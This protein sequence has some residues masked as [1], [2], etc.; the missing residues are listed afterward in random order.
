MGVSSL[1]ARPQVSPSV[2]S[3]RA[4]P[5]NAYT[6]AGNASETQAQASL[7]TQERTSSASVVIDPRLM[8]EPTDD[9]TIMHEPSTL[10]ESLRSLAH[11]GPSASASSTAFTH[12]S[13]T[14]PSPPRMPPP[15]NG[16]E[17]QLSA[18]RDSHAPESTPHGSRRSTDNAVSPDSA[19][20]SADSLSAEP[21]SKQALVPKLHVY[22][23]CMPSSMSLTVT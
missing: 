21:P 10:V 19:R 5:W 20:P 15:E 17:L 23:L 13:T 3:K 8:G 4:R 6:H 9:A 12:Q 7:A 2:L 16:P 22:V 11:H 1:S 18:S 14:P